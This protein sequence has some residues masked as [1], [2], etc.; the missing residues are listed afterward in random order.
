MNTSADGLYEMQLRRKQ[1]EGEVE[2]LRWAQLASAARPKIRKNWG[3]QQV[4]L[5]M[6]D[7]VGGLQCQLQARFASEL[8]SPA[9]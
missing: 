3:F 9:C 7:M 6:G 2:R 4:A 1:L 8:S 5:W